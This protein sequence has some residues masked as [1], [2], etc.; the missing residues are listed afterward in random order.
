MDDHT[1]MFC[2]TK[3]FKYYEFR[4]EIYLDTFPNYLLTLVMV[5]H[6]VALV[7]YEPISRIFIKRLNKLKVKVILPGKELADTAVTDA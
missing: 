3:G 7:N 6:I 5:V 1:S 2:P 4:H